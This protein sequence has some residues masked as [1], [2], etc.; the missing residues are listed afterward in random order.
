MARAAAMR[1]VR[2][3]A[4]TSAAAVV[5]AVV[6]E[7]VVGTIDG[8]SSRAHPAR[9]R[10]VVQALA[11]VPAGAAEADQGMVGLGRA[12]AH[13]RE[14]RRGNQ[15]RRRL[16]RLPPRRVSR[17][18]CG[19]RHQSDQNPLWPS[20]C[21]PSTADRP[22]DGLAAVSGADSSDR[23]VPGDATWALGRWRQAVA[24]AARCQ[25]RLEHQS[26]RSR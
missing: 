23:L 15:R 25:S 9:Q 26:E 22:R 20:L 7:A 5:R 21:P 4:T 18:M 3:A 10:G 1:V 16:E 24:R 2:A 19:P 17:R 13:Q 14:R 11:G 12:A 8:L 6:P